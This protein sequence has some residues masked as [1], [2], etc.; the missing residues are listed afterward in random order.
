MHRTLTWFAR[1]PGLLFTVLMA[2]GWIGGGMPEWLKSSGVDT[3]FFLLF[4][5]PVFIGFFIS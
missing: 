3:S 4:C 1:I 2:S 5:L